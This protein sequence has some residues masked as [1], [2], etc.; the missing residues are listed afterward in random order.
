MTESM[1]N[2][3]VSFVPNG[4]SAGYWVDQSNWIDLPNEPPGLA[5][6]WVDDSKRIS[7]PNEPPWG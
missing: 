7:L 4:S 3:V 1:R 5:G 2:W 6:D